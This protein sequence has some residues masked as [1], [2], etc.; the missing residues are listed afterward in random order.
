MDVQTAQLTLLASGVVAFPSVGDPQAS[1]I[2]CFVTREAGSPATFLVTC[3]GEPF[4]NFPFDSIIEVDAFQASGF[5]IDMFWVYVDSRSFRLIARQTTDGDVTVTNFNF[6]VY[7][8]P[9]FGSVDLGPVPPGPSPFPPLPPGIIV[10]LQTAYDNSAGI[11]VIIQLA[12]ALGGIRILDVAA[13]TTPAFEVRSAN[14]SQDSIQVTRTFAGAGIGV[15]VSMSAATTSNAAR[16]VHAGIATAF[17]MALT[18]PTLNTFGIDI[19]ITAGLMGGI[20]ISKTSASAGA[21]PLNVSSTTADTAGIVASFSRAPTAAV[22]GTAEIVRIGANNANFGGTL[23]QIFP[24][25]GLASEIGIRVRTRAL[26]TGLVITDEVATASTGVGMLMQRNVSGSTGILLQITKLPPLATAGTIVNF[27][28]G[29]NASGTVVAMTH[30]GSGVGIDIAHSGAGTTINI[31]KTGGGSGIVLSE[32]VTLGAGNL[33]SLLRTTDSIAILASFQRNPAT[34]GTTGETIRVSSNAN[35]T[36]HGIRILGGVL[37]GMT[38]LTVAGQGAG[39][40]VRIVEDIPGA[41]NTG[42]ALEIV[43]VLNGSTGILLSLSKTPGAGAPTPGNIITFTMGGVGATTGDVIGGT[44][45]ATHTGRFLT[46]SWLGTGEISRVTGAAGAILNVLTVDGRNGIGVIPPTPATG[47]LPLRAIKRA[48]AGFVGSEAQEFHGT[49]TTV[50]AVTADIATILLSD[51]TAYTFE[52]HVTARAA[53]GTE[54]AGYIIGRVF[55]RQAAGVATAV[56]ALATMLSNETNLAAD[57]SLE[58]DGGNNVVVRVT[59]VAA[60]TYNWS[61]SIK[62]TPVATA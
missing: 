59:G 18:G 15:D 30:A 6:K 48:G 25:G 43:R 35:A 20:N 45:T 53:G 50:G 24:N 19:S 44:G 29:V 37:A 57:A 32:S 21:I 7:R 12:P 17:I 36:G 27:T 3:D 56:G 49:G 46:L 55:R 8:Q 60:Q 26:G 11:P 41:A 23:L 38:N 34:A 22:G 13:L 2:G 10:D 33:L 52:A 58:V 14:S 40:S 39:A 28:V 5:P 42:V 16:I 9:N 51:N 4:A 31:A 47:A 1:T 62:A 54:W 61:T